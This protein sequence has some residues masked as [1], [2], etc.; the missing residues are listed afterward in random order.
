MAK[1]DAALD[2][3]GGT[4][5]FFDFTRR[6]S[7]GCSSGAAVKATLTLRVLDAA[8]NATSVTKT[9]RLAK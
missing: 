9:V 4:Y 6:R 1:G 5:V 2:G 8:G 7:S 3:A